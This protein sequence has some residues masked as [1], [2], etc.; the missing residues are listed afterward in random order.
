[1]QSATTLEA[2]LASLRRLVRI[3]MVGVGLGRFLCAAAVLVLLDFS[4][5]RV[6]R[7]PRELRLALLVL[8]GGGLLWQFGRQLA[9]PF[10]KRLPAGAL[11]LEIERRLP[12]STDLLASALHFAGGHA[13]GTPSDALRASVIAQAEGRASL[14]APATLVRWRR[15]REWLLAAAAALVLTAVPVVL[16][17]AAAELWFK[18]NVL[19][20]EVE[21]PHRTRLTALQ[22]PKYVPRGESLT[23]GV[24]AAGAIPRT[25]RLRLRGL[26]SNTT[27]TIL[28]ERADDM[29]FAALS[30][31]DESTAFSVQAGD[32]SLEERRIEVIERPAVA[33]ARMV[34]RPPAYIAEKPVE[35]VW[36][37]PVF[38]VPKGSEATIQIE[39]TKPLSSAECRV[40]GGQTQSADLGGARSVTF[41]LSVDRGLRCNVFM[42][43]EYGIEAE[44]PFPVEIRAIKDQPPS[45]TVLASGIGDVAVP[46]AQIPLTVRAN[47]DYGVVSVWLEAAYEGP[48][49][50]VEYPRLPLWE[51]PAKGEV[52]VEHTVD[53]RGMRLGARGRF[54][55]T[56]GATDNC[57]VDRPN[58]GASAPLSLRLVTLHELLAA[59]L[60]RQQDLRRD[61]EQ[62][63]ARQ[64]EVR[65]RFAELVSSGAGRAGALEDP[66][67]KERAL[68]GALALT[69]E[70]YGDVLAQMLN[71]RAV[72]APVY[73]SRIAG[74]VQPL[75]AL[76]APDGSILSAADAVRRT[77]ADPTAA[78][79]AD[80][81]MDSVLADMDVVRTRMML[82]ENYAAIVT[83]VQE[84]SEQEREL[85][86]RTEASGPAAA[87]APG[88]LE[89]GR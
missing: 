53:L 59:L 84:I 50:R 48:A 31:L 29:F 9:S 40:A 16:E 74:I 21:W 38:D 52:K 66:E 55:V 11:A 10:V 4:V 26:Q 15:V 76:G 89:D 14:I 67:G 63:I 24:R 57:T 28:M 75:E 86:R 54:V 83:S 70:Q 19:L 46:E 62:Q 13:D 82:L 1:V 34:V 49:G 39:A 65:Q 27:R 87:S 79:A 33:R 72:S 25:A 3:A 71:N 12:R 18:R 43:D 37:S 22:A 35:L 44:P 17:P 45:V 85:L 61:L 6:L 36:N 47:D 20:L 81:L 5:D 42:R 73:E 7:L 32:A 80:G 69:G 60:I 8:W 64:K 58:I 2:K 88:A 77:A 56:V 41:E 68:S 78:A 23:I 30:G 51:G